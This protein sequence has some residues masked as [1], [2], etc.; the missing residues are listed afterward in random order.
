M[1][2]RIYDLS[3]SFSPNCL[4]SLAGRCPSD[5]SI[6]L[7]GCFFS[8]HV[9]HVPLS[10]PCPPDWQSFRHTKTDWLYLPLLVECSCL[11]QPLDQ[12]WDLAVLGSHIEND[13]FLYFYVSSEFQPKAGHLEPLSED[14][15]AHVLGCGSQ[16][17][18]HDS[19]GLD[20]SWFH[21]FG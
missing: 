17:F 15:F 7:W 9:M 16:L 21:T 10:E 20:E 3:P 19:L 14:S 11:T 13:S 5:H 1:T 6:A 2:F 8:L 4:A 12:D 18:L